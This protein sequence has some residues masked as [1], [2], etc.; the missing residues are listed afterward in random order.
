MP[1]EQLQ[2]FNFPGYPSYQGIQKRLP[3]SRRL[4]DTTLTN[5]TPL[6]I[7]HSKR[8]VSNPT[9]KREPTFEEQVK[10]GFPQARRPKPEYEFADLRNHRGHVTEKAEKVASKKRPRQSAKKHRFTRYL[11]DQEASSTI[12]AVTEQQ[13][14]NPAEL[15][16]SSSSSSLSEL[17]GPSTFNSHDHTQVFPSTIHVYEPEAD[18]P[19]HPPSGSDKTGKLPPLLTNTATSNPSTDT[20]FPKLTTTVPKS[21]AHFQNQFDSDADDEKPYGIGQLSSS[22]SVSS[23]SSLADEGNSDKENVPAAAIARSSSE[24]KV[25]NARMREISLGT[26]RLRGEGIEEVEEGKIDKGKREMPVFRFLVMAPSSEE[27]E[28]EEASEDGVQLV[29]FEGKGGDDGSDD[30]GGEERER[31]TKRREGDGDEKPKEK[32]EKKKGKKAKA[33][34]LEDLEAMA[35]GLLG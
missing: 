4:F 23:L 32:E 11:S 6:S 24:D 9:E 31:R 12:P 33:E 26:K 3:R 16:L 19:P 1:P 14:L 13:V 18:P 15:P 35:S 8:Y 7:T 5:I 29:P 25:L 17:A 2:K 22:S 27:R 30:V 10:G 34:T 20:A 28:R 21:H